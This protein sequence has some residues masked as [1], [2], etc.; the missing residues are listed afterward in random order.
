MNKKQYEREKIRKTIMNTIKKGYVKDIGIVK[1]WLI[2]EICI[3]YNV[4]KRDSKEIVDN[5]I[6]AGYI[7]EDQ[8]KNLWL[9]DTEIELFNKETQETLNG[10]LIYILK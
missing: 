4:N 1:L 2:G 8:N 6:S 7:K 5:L 10:T 3:E 9:S